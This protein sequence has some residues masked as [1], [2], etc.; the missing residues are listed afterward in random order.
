MA[1]MEGA[2]YSFVGA[3]VAGGTVSVLGGGK[4]GNGAMTGAFDYLFNDCAHSVF[5]CWDQ[6]KTWANNNLNFQIVAAG[7]DGISNKITYSIHPT[8]TA[9]LGT[10]T[11]GSG[12]G[13]GGSLVAGVNTNIVSIGQLTETAPLYSSTTF[14]GSAE[15][16]GGCLSINIL[17]GGNVLSVSALTGVG[18]GNSISSTLNHNIQVQH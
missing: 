13:W 11:V 4:F 5:D 14:C 7:G 15:G 10:F 1:S 9:D 18:M 16:A 3:M 12:A 6:F 17:K 2:Q 8:D